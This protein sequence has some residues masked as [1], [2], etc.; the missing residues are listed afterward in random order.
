MSDLKPTCDTAVVSVEI[1]EQILLAQREQAL[2][3][4][5]AVERTLEAIGRPVSKPVRPLKRM[6]R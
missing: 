1:F 2:Q 6:L 4:V 5:Y 3:A